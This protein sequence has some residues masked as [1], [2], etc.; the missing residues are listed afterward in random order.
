MGEPADPHNI[1]PG[2]S[3][4]QLSSD[5]EHERKLDVCKDRELTEIPSPAVTSSPELLKEQ[6]ATTG[7]DN[8]PSATVNMDASSAKVNMDVPSSCLTDMDCPIC[9]TRYDIYRVPKEL[10]CKHNFCAV[11]LK[12]LIHNQGGTWLI[13]CPICR[14]STTVFGGL[15]CTLQNQEL[16]MSKLQNP[17]KKVTDPAASK[18]SQPTIRLD[19]TN[20]T[21]ISESDGHGSL[22]MAAKRLVILLLM[23]VILLI[24]ILQFICKGIVKWVLGCILG[25][26]VTITILLCFNP[27]CRERP[28]QTASQ[29]KETQNV[30]SV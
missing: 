6:Q 19:S 24:V 14:G 18:P 22:R 20:T 3:T 7:A 23:L 15:V 25:V 10:S 13:S 17:E 5:M 12:I 8:V 21:W 30:S 11:C 16:L 26:V 1:A 27:Y 28:P 4:C 29:E 9:F 2:G